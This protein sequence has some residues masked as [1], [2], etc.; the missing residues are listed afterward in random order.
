MIRTL[1]VLFT[2]TLLFACAAEEEPK[3]A[4]PQHQLESM[5]KA[6]DVEDMMQNAEQERRDKMD[7]Q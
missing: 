2:T 3:G 5:D 7:N 1:L 4:I 6:K